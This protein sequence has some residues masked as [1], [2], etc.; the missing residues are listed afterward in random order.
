MR[1]LERRAVGERHPDDDVRGAMETGQED[2]HRGEEAR[3]R[4]DPE[5]ANG[6]YGCGVDLERMASVR[7][8][9]G[10]AAA[11]EHRRF[12][13]VQRLPEVFPIEVDVGGLEVGPLLLDE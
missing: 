6:R 13:A 2:A 9:P 4:C 12:V 10:V 3:G 8:V 11:G 7:P 5:I 1:A